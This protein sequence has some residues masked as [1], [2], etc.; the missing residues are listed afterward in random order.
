MDI[1]ADVEARLKALGY[2]DV[3]SEEDQAAITYAINRASEQ[4]T[5]NINRSEVPEGL[6]Y[7]WVDMTAGMFLYDKKAAGT[8]G[9]AFDFSAPEKADHRR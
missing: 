2:E 6:K 3:T 1:R 7:T 5:A 9:E 4:I 8:L